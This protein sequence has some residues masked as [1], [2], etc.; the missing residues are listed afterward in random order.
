MP[1]GGKTANETDAVRL[2]RQGRDGRTVSLQTFDTHQAPLHLPQRGYFLKE[3]IE[4]LWSH[5]EGAAQRFFDD[6]VRSLRWQRLPAFKGRA[7]RVND[8]ET[9]PVRI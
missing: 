4:R 5:Y 2:H 7:E 8:F 9:V 6:W 3:Q 1:N